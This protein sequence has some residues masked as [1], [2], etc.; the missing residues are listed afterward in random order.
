[1]NNL[2]LK[3][4]L[5]KADITKSAYL[6]VPKYYQDK[7]DMEHNGPSRR[8]QLN[9][10][11]TVSNLLNSNDY[12]IFDKDA[13]DDIY[14]NNI[15]DNIS[16]TIGVFDKD[17]KNLLFRPYL[18]I[19]DRSLHIG[20]VNFSFEQFELIKN[21]IN[22]QFTIIN[23]DLVKA[24]SEA[25]IIES[26]E[27]NKG[28]V[29]DIDYDLGELSYFSE[30]RQIHEED[31]SVLF[32]KHSIDNIR[33]SNFYISSLK[34]KYIKNENWLS[35]VW[36]IQNHEQEALDSAELNNTYEGQLSPQRNTTNPSKDDKVNISI[37]FWMKIIAILFVVLIFK[38]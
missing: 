7:E 30:K 12:I 27:R 25:E 20:D 16:I 26:R 21:I 29:I 14:L 9:I 28:R 8:F 32:V 37:L 24:V 18:H 36:S 13:D 23:I 35:D 34:P 6:S 33:V 5:N 4:K 10:E 1:M 11:G 15:A 31:S 2:N 3:I 19:A 22:D 38:I 17:D